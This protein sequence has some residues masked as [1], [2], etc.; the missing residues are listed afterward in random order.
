MRALVFHGPSQRSWGE[1]PD[2]G[3]SD[4]TPVVAAKLR[5]RFEP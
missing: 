1:V 5:S 4:A 2:P 3:V